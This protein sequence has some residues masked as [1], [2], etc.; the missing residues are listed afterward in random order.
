MAN[1]IVCL[2]SW[3]KREWGEIPSIVVMMWLAAYS[4]ITR[5]L[6][7]ALGFIYAFVINI[8]RVVQIAR[9]RKQMEIFM[10]DITRISRARYNDN[11]ITAVDSPTDNVGDSDSGHIP[12]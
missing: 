6:Y 8:L 4:L 2:W 11:A 12:D 1:T 3:C 9:L 5:D 10:R 7:A